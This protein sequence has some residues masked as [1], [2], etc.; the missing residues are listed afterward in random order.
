MVIGVWQASVGFCKSMTSVSQ[1]RLQLHYTGDRRFLQKHDNM[2]AAVIRN[3][4]K[5]SCMKTNY[6]KMNWLIP[7]LGIA[8][9]A[10]TYLAANTYLDLARKVEAEQAFVV[11]VDRVFQA[12]QLSS[13]LKTIQEGEV[14]GATR[15]LDIL[16]CNQIL[17]LDSDRASS[18][19]RTQ[20]LVEMAF[21]K[22]AAGRPKSGSGPVTGSVQK[23]DDAQAAAEKILT[24][25]LAS[26][27]GTQMK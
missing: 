5:L 10:G 11:T 4:T 14:K 3:Q 25:N 7:T 26:A 23:D 27:R 12:Q 6:L 21:Q 1:T 22:I 24:V 8:V 9:V 20:A 17:R 2:E 18:D 16:L 13:V 19:A 15:R